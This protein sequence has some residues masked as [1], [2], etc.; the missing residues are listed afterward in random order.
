[1]SGVVSQLGWTLLHFVWQG[2]LVACAAALGMVVLRNSRP[3]ARYALACAALFVCV[4]WPA[5]E[6]LLRMQGGATGPAAG[7]A[8][9]TAAG[10]LGHAAG[11]LGWLQSHLPMIVLGWAACAAALS[12]RMALGLWWIGRAARGQTA[13]AEWEARVAAMALRFGITRAVRVRVVDSIASPVTAGWWRPLIVLPS[14][15]LTGM[16]AELLEA[17]IAHELGHVKRCDYLVNLLQNMAEML[18]FYHPAVWWLSHCIRTERERIADDLAAAHVGQRRLALALSELEKIQFSRGDLALAANG[19]DLMSRIKRL[20]R[21]AQ[22]QLHWKAALPVL[23]LSLALVAGCAQLPAKPQPVHTRAMANFKSC[24]KPVWPA[25][26][27]RDENTGTVVLGF[28]IDTDGKVLD[29]RLENSSGYSPLD[30]AAR[31]GISK[32]TFTP[33]TSDGVPVRAWMKMQYV[34]TLT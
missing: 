5:A 20:L 13:G 30:E 28:L 4:A 21:P 23:G 10:G 2:A 8:M 11:P 33:A 22:Q 26:S 12:T 1:M 31:T 32:C 16:P 19:G 15:L 3:Q 14:S 17:L 7:A 9:F 34:W 24:A 6:L 29:S 18:L 27:L 25:Q